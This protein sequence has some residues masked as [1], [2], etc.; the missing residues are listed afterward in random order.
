MKAHAKKPVQ[1]VKHGCCT[2]ILICGCNFIY[3]LC[4]AAQTAARKNTIK[5]SSADTAAS[6]SLN[7]SE[8]QPWNPMCAQIHTYNASRV[9]TPSTLGTYICI[10]AHML[11]PVAAILPN[12]P[13]GRHWFTH[14]SASGSHTSSS[15]SPSSSSSSSGSD[16]SSSASLVPLAVFLL[17]FAFALFALAEALALAL[18]F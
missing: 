18:A 11:K 15:S 6:W 2:E 8:G 12:R 5:A 7:P 16:F 4:L 17:A 1:C 9:C 3:V 13:R 10:R 14:S